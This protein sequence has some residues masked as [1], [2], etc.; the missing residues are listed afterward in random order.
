MEQGEK[1][2]VMARRIWQV[3]TG[4][5]ARPY[6]RY[7]VDHGVV[8]LGPG[9]DG[10]WSPDNAA[11][12]KRSDLRSFAVGAEPGDL[13]VAR[14]GASFAVAVGEF[15]GDYDWSPAFDD[16]EGWDLQ[17]YRRVR[18]FWTSERRFDRR[19]FPQSR[20][21]ESHNHLV[22]NWAR[23]LDG[24]A[25]T[26]APPE[27]DE[28]F[29]LP[30]TETLLMET[31]LDGPLR[32]VVRRAGEWRADTWSWNFGAVPSEELLTHVTVPLLEALGWEPEEIAVK[33]K[34]TD[35]ALFHPRKREP[36][37]CRIVVEGK[38]IGGGLQWAGDQA[39]GYIKE[40]GLTGADV[41]VTDGICYRLHRAP[42]FPEETALWANLAR[43]KENVTKL[44]DALRHP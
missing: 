39:R 22:A 26:L 30:P 3:G 21:S 19:V 13:V 10:K 38:R 43:P 14:R 16:I 18:W 7:F 40:L 12:A 4:D 23:G 41:L 11:Y 1:P 6:D 15:V 29:S 37:N 2:P 28:P 8:L 17:H 32:S 44:F 20:F 35:L 24:S 33:W 5:H 31:M 34:Y 27:E 42:D 9:T 36:A 25:G